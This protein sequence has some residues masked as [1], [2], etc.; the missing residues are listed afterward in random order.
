[1][2]TVAALASVRGNPRSPRAIVISDSNGDGLGDG[3]GGGGGGGGGDDGGGGD[4]G[5]DDGGGDSSG[6]GSSN[7]HTHLVSSWC[8]WW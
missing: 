7:W 1:M 4:G 6:S 3:G 5:G 8:L 2:V